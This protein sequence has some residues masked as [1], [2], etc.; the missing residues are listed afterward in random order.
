MADGDDWVADMIAW[1]IQYN[2]LLNN[3]ISKTISKTTRKMLN[4]ISDKRNA[5]GFSDIMD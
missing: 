4:H 3:A 5:V 1:R 2:R